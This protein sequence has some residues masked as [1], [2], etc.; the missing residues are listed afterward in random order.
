MQIFVKVDIDCDVGFRSST[1][2]T[3]S[4]E[5][6]VSLDPQSFQVS[7][8]DSLEFY[9]TFPKITDQ[10]AFGESVGVVLQLQVGEVCLEA[11][12]PIKL[13]RRWRR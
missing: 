3:G 2:P 10:P 13:V 11:T 1:Q 12:S 5:E 7:A 6:Q 9:M 8:N 4:R